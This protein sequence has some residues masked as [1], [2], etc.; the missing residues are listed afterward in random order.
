M[1]NAQL[2]LYDVL[3][4]WFCAY[5]TLLSTIYLVEECPFVERQVNFLL[6]LA[7]RARG[8]WVTSIDVTFWKALK[9]VFNAVC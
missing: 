7:L 1:E 5:D 2:T 4:S 6:A 3:R 9:G 8:F